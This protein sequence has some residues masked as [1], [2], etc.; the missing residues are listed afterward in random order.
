MDLGFYQVILIHGVCCAIWRTW[1]PVV[2]FRVFGEDTICVFWPKNK[3][4][5]WRD[6]ER[7]QSFV[8]LERK[9]NISTKKN[10]FKFESTL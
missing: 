5:V 4:I 3:E 9:G 10:G 8:F 2:T 1:L 7:N 6:F